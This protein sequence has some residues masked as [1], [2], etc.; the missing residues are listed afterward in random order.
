MCGTQQHDLSIAS[1]ANQAGV[2]AGG[3]EVE[4]AGAA[5]KTAAT[6]KACC[7]DKL[8]KLSRSEGKS[9]GC[10]LPS[11]NVNEPRIHDINTDLV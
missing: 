5:A 4:V 9:W 1:K 8:V 2:L 6:H 11:A 7:R 3:L 10:D